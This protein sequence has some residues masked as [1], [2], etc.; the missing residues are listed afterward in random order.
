MDELWAQC[1][2]VSLT[3]LTEKV[4]VGQVDLIIT[5]NGHKLL[6]LGFIFQS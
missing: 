3:G 5:T 4:W 2:W 6:L 1:T